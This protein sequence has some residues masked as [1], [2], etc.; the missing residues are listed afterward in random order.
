MI[1]TDTKHVD[2]QNLY[3]NAKTAFDKVWNDLVSSE[4]AKRYIEAKKKWEESPCYN[5]YQELKRICGDCA[6]MDQVR[7]QYPED[8]EEHR[9]ARKTFENSPAKEEFLIKKRL[10][11]HFVIKEAFYIPNF[12]CTNMFEIFGHDIND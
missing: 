11:R 4:D 5:A 9:Q 3:T 6:D 1:D 10:I 8:F 2:I 7:K 12:W